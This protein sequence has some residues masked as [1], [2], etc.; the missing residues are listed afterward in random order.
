[1]TFADR[2]E[3]GVR[4]GGD[5]EHFASHAHAVVLGLPRGGVVV[6]HAVAKV[7]GLPLHAF[8]VRKLGVPGQE[9][10]AMGAVASGGMHVLNEEVI[11]DLGVSNSVIAEVLERETQELMRRETLYG[12]APWQTML[13]GK[14]AILVDDGLATGSTMK[15]AVKAIRLLAP[16]MVVVAVPTGSSE[17]CD[18]LRALADQL[19]CL[20]SPE[21]YLSVGS[22]YE[23]FSEVPDAEVQRLLSCTETKTE[24]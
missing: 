19:Y 9:E 1:M 23:E 20:D 22:W 3:A 24:A 17:A 4:L 14:T 16:G 7:L 12:Q 18:E 15:A 10:L 13:R 2:R 21:P 11:A 6:A 8:L 5:L